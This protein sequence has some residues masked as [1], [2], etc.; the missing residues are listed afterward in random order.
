[1][2]SKFEMLSSVAHKT[3]VAAG[4]V[5]YPDDDGIRCAVSTG[6][7]P[8]SGCTFFA[9]SA[10]RVS[11]DWV[12]VSSAAWLRVT[13]HEDLLLLEDGRGLMSSGSEQGRPSRISEIPA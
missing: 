10:G 11:P 7:L 12:S 5:E 6:G 2:S 8:A 9:V 1:M 13:A 4:S 3:G